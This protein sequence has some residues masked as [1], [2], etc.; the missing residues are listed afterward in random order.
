M[1]SEIY[2]CSIKYG[3]LFLRYEMDTDRIMVRSNGNGIRKQS[4]KG[5]D[6][7]MLWEK[8]FVGKNEKL[9]RE[10][11]CIHFEFPSDF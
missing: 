2:C 4:T 7:N 8:W 3:L 9:S 11:F 10:F 5:R 6:E 1:K